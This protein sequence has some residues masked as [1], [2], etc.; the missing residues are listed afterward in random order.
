MTAE[1]AR[2]LFMAS[3]VVL[4]A[5]T[6]GSGPAEAAPSTATAKSAQ[7]VSRVPHLMRPFGHSQPDAASTAAP[8]TITVP[9][10]ALWYHGGPV[11][12]HPKVYLDFWG[13]EWLNPTVVDS[14]G[15]NGIQAENY[16]AA[17]LG[18]IGGSPWFNSQTQYCESSPTVTVQYGATTCPTN[19]PHVGTPSLGDT[20]TDTVNPVPTPLPNPTDVMNEAG[21]AAAHFNLQ[22]DVNAT[23]L[24]LTGTGQSFFRTV[25]KPFCAYH[26][27]TTNNLIFGYI[28]W[29]P[30]NNESSLNC[31]TNAV[32]AT[33]DSFG[34]G[35]FDG[36]SVVIGS[37]VA[38]AATDPLPGY[39]NNQSVFAWTNGDGGFE[40]GDNCQYQPNWPRENAYFGA[41]N[42]NFFAVEPLWSDAG[43]TCALEDIGGLSAGH[44]AAASWATNHRDVFVEGGDNGLWY[45]RW[46]G[47]GWSPWASL[48]GYLTS[49]PSAVSWG[50][51]RT[52]VFARG[53]DNALWHIAWTGAGWSQWES[54]GGGLLSGPGAAS[55]KSGALDVVAVGGDL[56]VWH[57]RWNGVVWSGWESLGGGLS[58][59]PSAVS[60][61]DG[62]DRV[63]IFAR[64]LDGEL[65]QDAWT[66][67]GWSGW[68]ARGGVFASGPDVTSTASGRLQVY[69]LAPDSTLWHEVWNGVTWSGWSTLAGQWPADPAAVST[70]GSGGIEL[71]MVGADAA[72]ERLVEGP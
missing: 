43:E 25:T 64:G 65:W 26:S 21:A 1:R 51:G 36:F 23:V 4:A 32:N 38:G 60:W 59:D 52:D 18:D 7:S 70:P 53:G 50:V 71:F 55:W 39:I 48:G 37:E 6:A 46:Y 5:T 72:A 29:V 35:H 67:S 47:T 45:R 41:G 57:R 13:A 66:G 31:G 68:L 11:Q 15:Y 2:N 16:I 24:V 27:F 10:G 30:D 9:G 12:V 49:A 56:A 28:P 17:F 63:D 61:R 62:S 33:N 58:S 44:A 34:H 20:W 54:L 42:T 40:T 69:G 14:G 22:G 19:V 3:I 8:G